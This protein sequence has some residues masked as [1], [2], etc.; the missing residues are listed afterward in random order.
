MHVPVDPPDLTLRIWV[1]LGWT[2][3]CGPFGGH[4]VGAHRGGRLM[5]VYPQLL[6][7]RGG[8]LVGIGFISKGAPLPLRLEVAQ[9]TTLGLLV[10]FQARA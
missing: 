2:P 6:P 4:P 8:R 3:A 5:M 9:Q 7:V 1:A 10:Q